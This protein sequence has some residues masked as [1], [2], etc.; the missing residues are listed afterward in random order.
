MP[1]E[2]LASRLYLGAGTGRRA[3][4]VGDLDG[5][6]NLDL[7]VVNAGSRTV[8]IHLG[9]GDGTFAREVNYPVG[10]GPAT[11]AIGSQLSRTW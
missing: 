1:N 10:E 4:A 2:T 7:A 5:D 9:N 6:L 3:V 11:I 8:S